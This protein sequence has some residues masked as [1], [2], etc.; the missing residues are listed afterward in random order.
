MLTFNR[1]EDISEEMVKVLRRKFETS[2]VG[3]KEIFNEWPAG[4]FTI[5]YPSLSIITIGDGV[6][7]Q[8]VNK[9]IVLIG[10]KNT[11]KQARVLRDTGFWEWDL[12][13]DLWCKNKNQRTEFLRKLEEVLDP[14]T[15]SEGRSGL[16]LEMTDYYNE[17]CSYTYLGYSYEDGEISA[18]RREWRALLKVKV[19]G[20]SLRDKL[21][22]V[23]E[24]TQIDLELKNTDEELDPQ[25]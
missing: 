23:M 17:I 11:N 3:F 16:H 15:M 5:N 1:K 24:T 2:K 22:F 6:F 19:D 18:Q 25:P 8:S 12:Q 4:N 7:S 21:E 10:P 9:P 14:N 20:R 13:L